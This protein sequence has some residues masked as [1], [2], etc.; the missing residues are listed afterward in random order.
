M[1]DSEKTPCYDVTIEARQA[2]RGKPSGEVIKCRLGDNKPEKR[3]PC[4]ELI[5]WVP[6]DPRRK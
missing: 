2:H 1:V 5:R 4:V 3:K 6:D